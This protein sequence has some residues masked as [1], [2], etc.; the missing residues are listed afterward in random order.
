MSKFLFFTDSHF[1][2]HFTEFSKPDK[3]FIN[4]RFRIQCDTLIKLLELAKEKSLPVIFGALPF[5]Q[6][7]LP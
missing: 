3:D 5:Q 2:A 4:N 7:F 6:D 1:S